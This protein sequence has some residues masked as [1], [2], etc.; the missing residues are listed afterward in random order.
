MRHQH[1]CGK[2]ERQNLLMPQI[3]DLPAFESNVLTQRLE[4]L[5]R[6]GFT[7][8]SFGSTSYAVIAVPALLPPGDYREVLRR[9]VAE[10]SEMDC[11]SDLQQ[12]ME[13]RLMAMACHSVIRANRKLEKE[14]IRA[15]LADL[16]ESDFATQCPHGRPVLIEFSESQ[17]ERMFRRT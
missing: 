10:F 2:V 6:L 7:V 8:E 4:T 12:D 15:L 14:E 3:L 9:M 11:S 13:E 16:D 17:L 5:E 1:G